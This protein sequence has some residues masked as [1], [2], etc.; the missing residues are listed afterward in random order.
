[1]A[2]ALQPLAWRAVAVA[3]S[4]DQAALLAALD[5]LRKPVA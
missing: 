2:A 4:P 1:V 5:G 3:A